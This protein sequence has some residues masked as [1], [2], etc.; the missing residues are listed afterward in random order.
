MKEANE[1]VKSME[2]GEARYRYVLVNEEHGG[3]LN[4]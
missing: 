1:A 2:E 3:K 4:A